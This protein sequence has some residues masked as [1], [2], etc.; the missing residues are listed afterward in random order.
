MSSELP[1]QEEIFK[2]DLLVPDCEL[3]IIEERMGR[4]RTE[5]TLDEFEKEFEALC[6]ELENEELTQEEIVDDDLPV[7]DWQLAILEE[8]MALCE[9]EDITKWTTWEEVQRELLQEIFEE[10]K[11]RKN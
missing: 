10:M 1:T 9:S 2:D 8:R 11:K 3:A 4:F 6:K 5:G 7:P